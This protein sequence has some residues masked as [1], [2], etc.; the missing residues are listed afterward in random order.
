VV[1]SKRLT[2]LSQEVV[3]IVVGILL[4]FGFDALWTNWDDRARERYHIQALHTDF[5]STI[6]LLEESL[7]TTVRGRESAF[8]VLAEMEAGRLQER[9][10]SVLAWAFYAL[11]YEVF[12]PQ[13]GAYD[14]L[15]NSGEFGL[16]RSD[17]LRSALAAYFGTFDDARASERILL[18]DHREFFHS[19][20]AVETLRFD[21]LL[22]RLISGEA[23]MAT[24]TQA[25]VLAESDEF[26]GWMAALGKDHL[27]LTDDYT[28]LMSGAETVLAL[29]E[30][31]R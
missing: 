3:V 17:S 23:L 27:D 21:Q 7:E 24:P 6:A 18:D 30:A 22:A 29:L 10:D 8:R 31:N 12:R 19:R 14:A 20:V 13:R 1:D 25:A 16:L 11:N 26:R 5:S 15:V 9:S 4:A 28:T 2:V